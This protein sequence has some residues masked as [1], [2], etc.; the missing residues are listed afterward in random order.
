MHYREVPTQR[1]IH[2]F[3]RCSD[4]PRWTTPITSTLLLLATSIALAVPIGSDV[5]CTRDSQGHRICD[6]QQHTAARTS[7]RRVA[8]VHLDEER[9]RP[10]GPDVVLRDD[11]AGGAHLRVPANAIAMDGRPHRDGIDEPVYRGVWV[12]ADEEQREAIAAFQRGDSPA[13]FLR[14]REATA[15]KSVVLCFAMTLLA[16]SAALL[17]LAQRRRY[18]IRFDPNS[19]LA[20]LSEGSIFRMKPEREVLLATGELR[21]EMGPKVRLV[22]TG[23]KPQTLFESL[24]AVDHGLFASIASSVQKAR[25]P[26]KTVARPLP[27][28]AYAST[29]VA[30][31]A[32]GLALLGAVSRHLLSVPSDTA[33]LTLRATTRCLYEGATL[34]PGAT[35]QWSQRAGA[36]ELSVH[37][38]RGQRAVI[39]AHLAPDRETS[40]TCSEA[41]F[42]QQNR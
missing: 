36:H 2:C 12:R 14:T 10:S 1:P 11:G 13:F 21:A 41:T 4:L 7:V 20:W 29:L 35:L 30:V 27:A 38:D 8:D 17:G 9:R 22:T 18:R 40:V 34:L 19:E 37:N 28:I 15:P 33:T 23:A 31:V 39:R 26:I 16:C 5:Y 25:G 3:E 6:V 32:L 42:T 24:H